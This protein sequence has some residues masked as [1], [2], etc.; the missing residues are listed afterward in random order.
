MQ[1]S[2]L[3]ADSNMGSDAVCCDCRAKEQMKILVEPDPDARL[4]SP[5]KLY[6]TRF[7]FNDFPN[8]T[9]ISHLMSSACNF[10]YECRTC[11]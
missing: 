8:L 5:D 6:I 2:R 10:R 1:A 11:I 4:P 7:I 9:G 3:D